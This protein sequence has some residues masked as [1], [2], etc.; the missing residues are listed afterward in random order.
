MILLFRFKEEHNKHS[1]C[2][3]NK[4]MTV[5]TRNTKISL[6]LQKRKTSFSKSISNINE[7]LS[8]RKKVAS[9]I[10]ELEV[11]SSNIR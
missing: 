9:Q 10:K 11:S 4:K 6:D 3:N 7:N 8:K 1:V 5:T 2:I